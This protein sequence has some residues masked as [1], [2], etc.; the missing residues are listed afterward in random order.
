MGLQHVAM[1]GSAEG[2]EANRLHHGT[3]GSE[4]GH[5]VPESGETEGLGS[6]PMVVKIE[7][8]EL[9][10][11]KGETDLPGHQTRRKKKESSRHEL[12]DR[13]D[14]RRRTCQ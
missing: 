8:R 5:M 6:F 9:K 4:E 14:W 12:R 2:R 1:V 13:Q 3:K 10:Q 11:V 7:G